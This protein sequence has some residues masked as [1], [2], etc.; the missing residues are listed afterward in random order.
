MNKSSRSSLLTLAALMLALV[1]NRL[2]NVLAPDDWVW[3]VH[4]VTISAGAAFAVLLAFLCAPYEWLRAKCVLASLSAMCAVDFLCVATNAQG[5]WYWLAFQALAGIGAASFYAFR[6]HD[7]HIDQ[8]ERNHLYCLRA[9]PR[10]PQDLI[11]S[12]AGRHGSDGG[13]SLFADN[14]VYRYRRGVLVKQSVATLPLNRY[15]VT[16]GAKI[17]PELIAELES[18]RGS[19]WSLR[20]N[21]LTVLGPIWRRHSG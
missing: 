20:R 6:A 10:S 12:L 5:Y 19:I 4:D 3:R 16:K 9:I 13:Y 14:H 11:I 15:H 7:T 8:L 17:T 1:C 18:L 21:C 2:G